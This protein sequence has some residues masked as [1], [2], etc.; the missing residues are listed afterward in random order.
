MKLIMWMLC[1]EVCRQQEE[2]QKGQ[3][4]LV[5]AEAEICGLDCHDGDGGGGTARIWEML[6]EP[7]RQD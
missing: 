5:V 4:S 7:S 6:G 3:E 2:K 1:Q